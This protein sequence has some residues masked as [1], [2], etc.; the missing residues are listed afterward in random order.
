M[1]RAGRRP[2]VRRSS[3]RGS[4]LGAAAAVAT[5]TGTALVLAGGAAPAG[6]A[7][8]SCTTPAPRASGAGSA[9]AAVKRIGRAAGTRTSKAPRMTSPSSRPPTRRIT[10]DIVRCASGARAGSGDTVQLRYSMVVWGGSKKLV[11][12]SWRQT[13]NST[14]FPLTKSALIKGFYAGVRGMRVGGRRVI[15]VP[16]SQ[17]YG[18][19]G[20]SGVPKNAT[21]IFVVDLVK[22]S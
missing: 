12:S 5:A 2:E 21:L 3:G 1:S 19:A 6:A 4:A 8:A 11:D 20:T 7:S 14:T 15:V 13:P 16:P 9:A 18:G 22:V 17:G 10:D